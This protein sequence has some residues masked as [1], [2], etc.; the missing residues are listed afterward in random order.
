MLVQRIKKNDRERN[1]GA[2]GSSV[3]G[4]SLRADA[5][6]SSSEPSRGTVKVQK[7][8]KTGLSALS[9][10]S[11]HSPSTGD[12][13]YTTN[14]RNSLTLTKKNT[15]TVQGCRSSMKQMCVRAIFL[16]MLTCKCFQLERGP[17]VSS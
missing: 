16:Q 8:N 3:I 11:S 7:A 15:F 5:I 12:T 2:R 9:H 17:G 6:F 14:Q 13:I 1:S 4:A 10:P